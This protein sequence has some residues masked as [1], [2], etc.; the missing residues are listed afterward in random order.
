MMALENVGNDVVWR[1]DSTPS[2][3]TGAVQISGD[4]QFIKNRTHPE[5]IQHIAIPSAFPRS[6]SSVELLLVYDQW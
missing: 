1:G 6:N 5:T 2:S 4:V 3:Q